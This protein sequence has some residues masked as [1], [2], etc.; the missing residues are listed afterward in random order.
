MEI[1]KDKVTAIK[2]EDFCL[3][4]IGMRINKIWKFHKWIPIFIQMAKMLRELE[5]NKS[6]G[7]LGGNYWF[8]RNIICIQYWR[9]FEY[10]ES[11]AKSRD[12]SHLPAWKQFIQ[13]IGTNGDVGIWHETYKV[14][15]GSYENIYVNMPPFLLGK[16]GNLYKITSSNN[17]GRK[18]MNHT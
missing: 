10:L 9:S 3:F 15:K 4:M 18:R 17:S 11:F 6:I 14:K 16:I 13:R 12:Y 5:R 2:D 8:G 7:C 1:I